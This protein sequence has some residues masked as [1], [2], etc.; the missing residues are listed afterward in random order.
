MWFQNHY[1]YF[2]YRNLFKKHNRWQFFIIPSTLFVK[3]K[4]FNINN[5]DNNKREFI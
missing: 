3:V 4:L 2:K 5:N 1:H